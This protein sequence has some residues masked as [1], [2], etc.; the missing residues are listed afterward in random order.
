ML[1]LVLR[2]QKQVQ[3]R[4]SDLLKHAID[5]LGTKDPLA[6]QVVATSEIPAVNYDPSDEAEIERMRDRGLSDTAIYDDIDS[7]AEF[8][9]I[10]REIS[11]NPA[12]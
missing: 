6:Y 7:D 12:I 3:I 5:L 4:S 11:G 1:F 2:Y 9:I 8:D 10:R